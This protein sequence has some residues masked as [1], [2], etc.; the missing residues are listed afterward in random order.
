MK[1]AVQWLCGLVVL[2]VTIWVN[3]INL[4][5]SYGSGPPYYNRTTNMDKW[6]SPIPFLITLDII[7]LGIIILISRIKL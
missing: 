7:A 5:E 1:R 3:Y 4:I 2:S 6:S